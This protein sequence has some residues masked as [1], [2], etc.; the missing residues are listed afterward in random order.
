[1]ITAMNHGSD[2]RRDDAAGA[3]RLVRPG[4]ALV[5]FLLVLALLGLLRWGT[6][7]TAHH[8]ATEVTT[9][10]THAATTATTSG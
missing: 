9:T 1:M 4:I 7:S 3:G 5:A 6:E 10:T 8:P 2:L